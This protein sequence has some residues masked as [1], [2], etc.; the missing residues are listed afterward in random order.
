MLLALLAGAAVT[1]CVGSRQQPVTRSSAGAELVLC[2]AEEVFIVS[3]NL[4]A[5][6]RKVWSWR[7]ADCPDIPE[8]LRRAFRSTDDCKPIEGGRGILISS[9]S[10]AVAL[11]ERETRR[12]LFFA[13]VPNAHSIELLPGGRLAAAAS[14][15][16]SPGGNRVVVFDLATRRET[17]S[18]RLSS[19]HGLVWDEQREL[20]WALGND[21]LRAYRV[22]GQGGLTNLRVESQTKLPEGNGHDL[23]TQ[24]GSSRL[25][26]ST[27]KHCWWFDRDTRQLTPHDALAETAKVKSY[28]VHPVTGRVAYV[29]AEG[30]NWWAE[31]VHFLKP[32]GVLHLPGQRLYKARWL[33]LRKP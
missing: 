30:T 7:A 32:P 20:L 4:D 15:S 5:E 17:A 28:S 19:A 8:S 3:V 11:V 24:P 6:P 12:A 29:Q 22:M 21:E 26:L 31:R 27:G 33:A 23:V 14:V 9:S 16:D 13:E 25:F 2:G 18:D 1:S 10:G